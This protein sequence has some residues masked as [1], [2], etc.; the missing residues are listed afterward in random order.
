MAIS[1][2]IQEILYAIRNAVYG[3]DVRGAIADG[4]EKCYEDYT[5]GGLTFADAVAGS[6]SDFPEDDDIQNNSVY[7]MQLTSVP[8]WFPSDYPTS[9]VLH[10]YVRISNPFTLGRRLKEDYILNSD[11]KTVWHRSYNLSTSSWTAWYNVINS[12]MQTEATYSG[13]AS[14]VPSS[15]DIKFNCLY[16]F[17]LTSAPDWFPS[18]YPTDGAPIMY[19]LRVGN[20]FSGNRIIRND[21]IYDRVMQPRWVR[22]WN[23]N[24]G[25][26]GAWTGIKT[27]RTQITVNPGTDL[28][29]SALNI[30]YWFG[31]TDVYLK[32]GEHVITSRSGL[33]MT[34]GKGVRIIGESGA[35]IKDHSATGLQYY[36]TFYCGKG[37]YEINNVI[38][39]CKNIRY[40]IHD[41]PS[42][43]DAPTPA[44]HVFKNCIMTLDNSEN[45]NWNSGTCIGGGLGHHTIV[46]IENCWFNG[47]PQ[48]GT[49]IK[50]GVT[51]HNNA[52]SG[53][54]SMIT[55]K[56]SYME[57]ELGTVQFGW[58]GE[59]TEQTLC[60]VSN[61]SF[62]QAPSIGPENASAYNIENMKMLQWN[63]H[64]RET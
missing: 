41:D 46:E 34:I 32:N 40:C 51:Y 11:F 12:Y 5:E 1:R 57:G 49:T 25:E 3:K 18:D 44:H 61:C 60:M 9:A 48:T 52:A 64:I 38:F 2:T 24:T 59:S 43:S 33:G 58:Y 54:K 17:Q 63:N 39:D 29:Q 13:S 35:K 21:Y 10:Y 28:I 8:A 20:E 26:W 7:R 42:S 62:G 15:N 23:I 36:A 6:A 22:E 14:V 45:S 31:D 56:D 27:G 55:I 47:I 37:D 30:A 16:R 53:A 50:C 19:F 4:I